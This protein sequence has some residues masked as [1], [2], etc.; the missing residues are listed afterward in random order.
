MDFSALVNV[1]FK[2]SINMY[3]YWNKQVYSSASW[4][5]SMLTSRKGWFSPPS[6]RDIKWLLSL[7]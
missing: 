3:A 1:H 4:N 2:K 6:I 7:K 5:I